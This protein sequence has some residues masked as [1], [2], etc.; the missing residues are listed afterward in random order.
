MNE[1][2]S[3][4][5]SS[6]SWPFDTYGFGGKGQRTIDIGSQEAHYDRDRNASSKR[7]GLQFN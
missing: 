2:D 7:P 4:G 5:L 3:S 1:D 6:D